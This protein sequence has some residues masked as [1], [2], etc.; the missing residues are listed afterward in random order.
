M[1]MPWES[2]IDS[3]DLHR[4]HGQRN[5]LAGLL[6]LTGLLGAL[7]TGAIIIAVVT[8]QN[9]QQIE[10]AVHTICVARQSA[11]RISNKRAVLTNLLIES[12]VHATRKGEREL[13]HYRVPAQV[14]ELERLPRATPIP[15][16]P[17]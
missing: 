10:Q 12:E 6:A 8:L 13:P 11:V 14:V 7:C 2:A 3:V 4:E 1:T 15:V 16:T 5:R 17:C 9:Q